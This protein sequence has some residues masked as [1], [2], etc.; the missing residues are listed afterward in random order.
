MALWANPVIFLG[1]RLPRARKL[2]TAKVRA[3]LVLRGRDDGTVHF[4]GLLVGQSPIRRAQL[5]GV[6]Q[7]LL[8]FVQRC[9]PIDIEE[10]Q[11]LQQVSARRSEHGLDRG[12]ARSL[13][14]DQ[15]DVA[16]DRWEPWQ[17]GVAR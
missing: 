8:A 13:G 11:P 10:H 14:D 5:Q 6:G 16:Q 12:G 7:A 1:F 4:P 9:A 17:P 2:S 15:R 3:E